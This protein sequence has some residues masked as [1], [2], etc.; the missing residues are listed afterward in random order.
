MGESAASNPSLQV[1]VSF[2]R[3]ENDSLSWE[4]WSSFS[5]NKYLEEVEKCA[6]PGSVAQKK[7]YFEAHYKKIAA[8]KAELLAQEK[9][10]E[11]DSFRSEDQDEIDLGGNADAELDKSD[12]QGF[13][14]GVTQE[15]SSVGE[16]HRTHVNDSEEEVAVSRDYE[17]SLVEMENKEVESR[18]NSSFQMDEP[19][20]VCVKHEESPNIEAEDV[21]EISHVVYKDTAKASEV[22]AKHVKLVQ[23]KES[24]V[25]SVN[26]GSNAA[27]TKKKPML[28]TSKASQISTPKS[29]KPASTPAKTV[30]PASST[31]KGSSSS[32]SRRQITSSGESRKFANKPL[33]MSLSLAPSNPERAPQATMR[34]S[35]IMEKMGD[36]D[37]VKRAFKTFQNSFNQPKASDEDKSS[38]K[39]QVPSR[40]TVSKVPTST[41]LR[42]ENGRPTKVE[43]ADKSGNAVRSTFGPKS[44]IRAEKGKES[45]RKIEEK[46]NAKEVERTR[47]QSKV[48]ED[49]KEEEMKRLKHNVKGTSTP[50][51]YRGQKVVK[52]RPE[53]VQVVHFIRDM[54]PT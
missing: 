14:E 35:L 53:K 47:L 7:A 4:R 43:S 11:K 38:I 23:P 32:L 20:D 19:E 54:Y 29:S 30:T 21:K 26:K 8:R 10:K 46:S 2:G 49:K 44:A 36:K 52:S 16:I 34:R 37:I 6:T 17:S 18:S 9:Q 39:K 3:F 31:K 51:F 15:T 24:K 40:G 1:S 41:A 27:K 5:P 13:D 48:K 22:E 28:P 42:K 45:S 50:A 33:H 12:T 25:T